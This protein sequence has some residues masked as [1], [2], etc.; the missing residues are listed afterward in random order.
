MC[1]DKKDDRTKARPR[2]T[3]VELVARSS[4]ESSSSCLESEWEAAEPIGL[5]VLPSSYEVAEENGVFVARCRYV[6]VA[7][8]GATEQA[9]LENLREA[10]EL[11]FERE[12]RTR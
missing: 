12:C 9:A 10:L 5:E 8:D 3:L 2:F 6:D 4:E 1:N 7:S 11:Y